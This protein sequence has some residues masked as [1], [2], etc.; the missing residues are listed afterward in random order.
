MTVKIKSIPESGIIGETSLREAAAGEYRSIMRLVEDA[1]RKAVA[2]S[3]PDYYISITSIYPDRAIVEQDGRLYAYPYT[4]G[5]DNQVS[6]GQPT[7]VII[8]HKPVSLREAKGVFLEAKD[9]AGLRWR[10]RVIKAG[11]SGNN[12]YYPDAV[13]RE[14][15][16]LFAAA[17]VFVKADSE[18]LKGAG[19]DFRNL[20]GRLS[21]PAFIEGKGKDNGEIH[22]TLDL[23]ASAGETPAKLLEAWNR[24]MAGDLFGFS[25]DA[26]G[27]SK[28]V[29]K[30]REAQKIT[31][32]NSVDLIIEPGA[33]GQLI[34]LLEAL[35]PEE[36]ADMKLRERMIEA[37][38]AANQGTLPDGLD[39]N[40]DAAIETAYREAV[41]KVQTPGESGKG[42]QSAA[43]SAAGSSLTAEDVASQI[44][45]VEAR[46][47]M[48]TV[49]AGCGLPDP[50]KQRLREHFISLERFT[51]AQVEAGIKAEREYLAKLSPTGKPQALGDTSFVESGEDR[52]DKVQKML[53]AFFDP[54]DRSVRSFK[55]CYIEITGDTRV[56]GHARDCN[57]SRMREALGGDFLEAVATSGFG[58]VLGDSVTRRMI[59]DYNERGQYDIWRQIVGTPVPLN[60][61]RTQER[62]RYGGYGDLPAVAQ[63]AAYA[64][65]TTPTD[66][67]AT[68]AP[69]KRGGKETISIESIKNDD[70]G[71]IQSIPARLSRAA[72]RTLS[73][74]VLDFIATN[75]NIYDGT[76]LFV[77]GHNNLGTTAL[78]AATLAAGRLQMLKQPEKDSAQRLGIGPKFI[79]GPADMEEAMT[80]LFRRNTEN[81]QTFIQSLSLTV[82]P[83]WYWTDVNNWYL[84]ADP[85][86]IPGL[87]IGFLDGQEEPELFVQ[88]NPTEGSLFSNDQITYKIR[89]IYGGAVKD[90][91]AFQGNVVP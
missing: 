4:L 69:T 9:E 53:D 14:A 61:F 15:T 19:K 21:D 76:A 2:P 43:I 13:L 10:I 67:K 29:G 18:H 84:V 28:R 12:N 39:M 55:E 40:D 59:A 22:A 73:K 65:L 34:N 90:F 75:A 11:Q 79:L 82:L 88:D 80:N 63:G 86:D 89:H 62:P 41:Q 74:F 70:V 46:A 64:A 38:K 25:I 35:N 57:V 51:E 78:S 42:A 3:K 6:V 87:E 47:N 58:N 33:G 24:N 7:E 91:R 32:V 52:A 44:R 54:N 16:G 71:F 26:N 23:L 17:R 1:V 31:K 50:S 83:V 8:D 27:S 68:Y 77:A 37:I 5:E 36:Q 81:D 60:D 45:M 20:I 30:L 72:K 49:I 85:M 48:R 56:T 66:E